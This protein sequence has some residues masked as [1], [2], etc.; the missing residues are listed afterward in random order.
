MSLFKARSVTGNNR[1]PPSS[2]ELTALPGHRSAVTELTKNHKYCVSRLPALPT[3]LQNTQAYS[4][5]N[6]YSDGKT[7]HAMVTTPN[8]IHVWNYKSLDSTPLSIQF[9]IDDDSG[10]D[11]LPFG[12]ITSPASGTN[13]DPGIAIISPGTGKVKFYSSVQNAPTIGLVNDKLSE[14]TLHL[15]VE[16]GE[17][18]TLAENIEPAGIAV[19]TSRK[20]CILITLRDLKGKPKLGYT[21]LTL[22]LGVG[23]VSNMLSGIF[24]TRN[25]NEIGDE[26]VSIKV[27]KISNNGLTEEIIITDSKGGFHLL[28]YQFSSTDGSPYVDSKRSF[29]QRMGVALENSLDGFIP[30]SSVLIKV[31]DLWPLKQVSESGLYLT[32]CYLDSSYHHHNDDGNQNL[33]ILVTMKINQTG[34]LVYGTHKLLKYNQKSIIYLDSKPRLFLPSPETTAFVLIDNSIILTD[35]DIS[36]IHSRSTGYYYKPRWE[37][38]ISLKSDVQIIG[39][40]YED[41][42]EDSNSSILLLTGNS[43]ALRIERFP[44][45]DP[46]T[47]SKVSPV[48]IVKSHLEQAI[49]YAKSSSI[50]FNLK[51][52]TIESTILNEAI[53]MV[54]NEVFTSNSIYFPQ[55][56]A[57]ISESLQ[58]KSSLLGQ[59]VNLVSTNY[60]NGTELA[61]YQ[62]I[63]MIEKADTSFQ[64]WQSVSANGSYKNWLKEV[65]IECGGIVNQND[66]DIVKDFFTTHLQSIDTVLSSFVLKLETNNVSEDIIS[67]LLVTS[68][69]EGTYQ[70]EKKYSQL[71]SFL[72][73][74]LWTL[75]TNLLFELNKYF[76]KECGTETGAGNGNAT[77]TQTKLKLIHFCQV[78]YYMTNSAI[79]YLRSTDP[80]GDKL[81]NYS[82]WYQMNKPIWIQALINASLEEDAE[83]IV[84]AYGDLSSLV[85]ILESKKESLTTKY[86]PNSMEVSQVIKSLSS[87][88]H[89]YGQPFAFCYFRYCLQNGKIN[90]IFQGFPTVNEYYDFLEAYFA[91]HPKETADIAWIQYLLD[92]KFLKAKASLVESIEFDTTTNVNKTELSL[93]IAKLSAVAMGESQ[94]SLE[95]INSE[96]LVVR[97]QRELLEKYISFVSAKELLTPQYFETYLL[98]DKVSLPEKALDKLKEA[99][100]KLTQDKKLSTVELID[101]LTLTIKDAQVFAD[102][103]EIASLSNELHVDALLHVIWVRLLVLANEWRSLEGSLL[104]KTAALLK[105]NVK[106]LEILEDIESLLQTKDGLLPELVHK[107]HTIKAD[108]SKWTRSILDQVRNDD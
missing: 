36:Y 71:R 54:A 23:F 22:Y 108:A 27:G 39:Q 105:D 73:A 46:T 82:Q 86:G 45:D 104:F 21:D 5:L 65:I 8:A 81:E 78:L 64:F 59:L 38:I 29:K 96:L 90:Q 58:L 87:Y 26:I 107:L 10:S 89:K 3:A 52:N 106:A 35:I 1:D 76:T 43:G 62:I 25:N 74:N 88:F 48:D 101:L 72:K 91:Q 24:G 83:I 56:N 84:E 16:N 19:A 60:P 17:Y 4:V 63:D 66:N 61:V 75:D 44:D 33:L 51:E 93:S 40:G 20:R 69:Y 99:F 13:E 70:N 7:S 11:L 49:F 95:P 18:I 14:I 37:D 98:N 28:T 102:A 103:A 41:K 79:E 92:N 47:Q 85:L 53:I 77:S 68:L 31:L 32:L 34:V 55:D 100:T 57:I 12:I 80:L 9:P 50:D 42:S 94:E 6:G 2:G 15:A 67:S 97:K 30:G